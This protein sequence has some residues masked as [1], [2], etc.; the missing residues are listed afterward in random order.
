MTAS[1]EHGKYLNKDESSQIP[2]SR[3]K[4]IENQHPSMGEQQHLFPSKHVTQLP[5]NSRP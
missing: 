2:D 1:E 4:E 5:N 3:S